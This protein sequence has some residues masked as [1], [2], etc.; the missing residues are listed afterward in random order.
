MPADY[1]AEQA[2]LGAM[3]LEREAIITARLHLTGPDDFDA[4]KHQVIY[5]AINTLFDQGRPA[6]LRT[7]VD[8]LRGPVN[9]GY[10]DTWLD[11]IGGVEYLLTLINGVPT[12]ANVREYAKIVRRKA[13]LRRQI[14]AGLRIVDLAREADRETADAEEA[15]AKARANAEA[16]LR[17]V[18]V[19][20]EKGGLEPIAGI[21][22]RAREELANMGKPNPNRVEFGLKEFD[23]FAW[24][25]G[26]IMAIHAPSGNGKS[27]VTRALLLGAAKRK[28]PC[29]LF[30]LEMGRRSVEQT[31]IASEARL[32]LNRIRNMDREPLSADEARRYTEAAERL[33][34]LP[35]HIDYVPEQ[36]MADI[37]AKSLA[38]AM[39]HGGLKVIAIDYAGIVGDTP[40]SWQ[41]HEQLL[42]RIHYEA[43]WLAR[44]LNALVIMVD[45]APDDMLKRANPTPNATD[46]ADARGIKRA[47]DHA[48]G[49]IIPQNCIE[50]GA[51]R[52]RVLP[53][54]PMPKGDPIPFN[55]Q[56]LE[57]VLLAAYTKGRFTGSGYLMP[58]YHQSFSGYIGNLAKRPWELTEGQAAYEATPG[59]PKPVQANLLEPRV[60]L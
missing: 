20:T 9:A 52:N 16:E 24:M 19:P 53:S 28:Q 45:Q 58:L 56:R 37:R 11:H 35:L 13:G 23:H 59:L 44:E 33:D 49:L 48:V 25:L 46:F 14:F 31:L 17:K 5:R 1:E 4:E 38:A 30:S 21:A 22:V 15:A 18:T 60:E 41:R 40:E 27:T 54:F 7:M 47:V 57:N 51:G 42:I 43:Q 12:T 26:E 36:R 55:D 50:N 39:K 34:P 32:S 29:A 10:P 3:I 2:V 6:D 8:I